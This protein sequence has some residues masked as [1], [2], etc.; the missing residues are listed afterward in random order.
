[1]LQPD[2]KLLIGGTLYA[3]GAVVNAHGVDRLLPDGTADPGFRRPHAPG[4]VMTV[5]LQ[6]DGHVLIAGDFSSV[7]GTV[8]PRTARLHGNSP[9][10]SL[11]IALVNDTAVLSWPVTSVPYQLHKSADLSQ[12]GSWS[13]VS[14]IPAISGTHLTVPVPIVTE[15]MFF[16]L[17]A[18]QT[19]Q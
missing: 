18:P 13:P 11:N 15:R 9:A 1:V 10:P 19:I 6:P 7:D 14:S 5:A 16:R 8:R 3:S 12:S 4:Y 2:G 17:A